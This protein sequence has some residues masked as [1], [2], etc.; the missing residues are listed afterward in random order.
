MNDKLKL[1][2]VMETI[3]LINSVLF[4][5]VPLGYP[6]LVQ[7]SPLP[8]LWRKGIWDFADSPQGQA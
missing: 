4:S 3:C 6:L 7:S 8:H 5:T 2:N 1:S